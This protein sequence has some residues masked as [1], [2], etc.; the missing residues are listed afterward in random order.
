MRPVEAVREPARLRLRTRFLAD[1]ADRIRELR[2][3]LVPSLHRAE[4]RY[5]VRLV[6]PRP[7]HADG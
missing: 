2:K 3:N 4:R 1:H 6:S 7:D 5:G